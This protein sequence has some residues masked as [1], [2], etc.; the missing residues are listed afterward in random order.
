MIKY[1]LTTSVK[2]IEK[3]DLTILAGDGDECVSVRSSGKRETHF[4]AR[5]NDPLR[6]RMNARRDTGFILL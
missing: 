4:A 3:E 6:N 2:R 5:F 1:I